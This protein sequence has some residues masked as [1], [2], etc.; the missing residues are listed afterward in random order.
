M[1]NLIHKVNKGKNLCEI[2]GEWGR[3]ASFDGKKLWNKNDCTYEELKIMN[4][5]LNSDSRY[6]DD[7]LLYKK[8]DEFLGQEAKIY[9]E[10]IQRKD[11]K[12]RAQNKE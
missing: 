4:F 12:L 6:R 5:T 10:E 1:E 2:E 11:R 9:L 3:Y 7:I 8:G